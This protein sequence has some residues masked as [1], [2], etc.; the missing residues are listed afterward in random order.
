MTLQT[1]CAA[2]T[3]DVVINVTNNNEIVAS[4]LRST[5]ASIAPAF[6]AGTVNSVAIVA[7]G[8]RVTSVDVVITT[9]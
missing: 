5:Y 3:N 6:L 1:L 2:L 4:F 7:S 9:E 8:A